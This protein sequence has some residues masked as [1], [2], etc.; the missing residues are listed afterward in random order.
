MLR[1]LE[2]WNNTRA[3]IRPEYTHPRLNEEN[4]ATADNWLAADQSRELARRSSHSNKSVKLQSPPT[5]ERREAFFAAHWS[6]AAES[7]ELRQ[8]ETFSMPQ[9]HHAL[10]TDGLRTASCIFSE[11]G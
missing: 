6:P 2:K 7:V 9:K 10:S 1:Q 4:T 3:R 5:N 11:C 8:S